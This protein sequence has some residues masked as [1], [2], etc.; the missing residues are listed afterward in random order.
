MNRVTLCSFVL[1]LAALYKR[2]LDSIARMTPHSLHR[3]AAWLEM[4]TWAFLILAMVLKYSGT[5]DALTPIAGGIHGFGF[6]CF[7]VMTIAVWINN[8]WPAGIGILGLIVSAIPFAALPFAI[9]AANRGYLKGGWR[10]SDASEEPRTL[11]DKG[12]AQLVRHPVRTIIIVLILIAV[13][14]GILL[15]LGPPVDV[16]SAIESNL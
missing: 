13:V 14:F 6:L 12:L 7:V 4:F 1:Y 15:Y 11:P 9:W 16:E 8:R 5:T 10:F 3:S 2:S